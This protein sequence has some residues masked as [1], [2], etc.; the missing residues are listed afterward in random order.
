MKLLDC[1]IELL[2]PAE[3]EFVTKVIKNGYSISK[4]ARDKYI[5]RAQMYRFKD[6]IVQKLADFVEKLQK[7]QKDETI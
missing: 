5:C 1:S 3:K 7:Q 6:K 4:Y 2:T